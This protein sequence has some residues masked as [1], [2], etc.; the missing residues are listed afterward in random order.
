MISLSFFL[1]FS[2][3]LFSVFFFFFKVP[4]YSTISC[5]STGH[6]FR[7]IENISTAYGTCPSQVEFSGAAGSTAKRA[8][9]ASLCSGTPSCGKGSRTQGLHETQKTSGRQRSGPGLVESVGEEEG[10]VEA[11]LTAEWVGGT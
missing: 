6:V 7:Y 2:I 1:K 5:F 8:V 11:V 10:E 9:S 4:F 3:L